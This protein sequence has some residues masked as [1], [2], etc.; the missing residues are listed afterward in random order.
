MPTYP[1]FRCR[2]CDGAVQME[3]N[4]NKDMFPS[5]GLSKKSLFSSELDSDDFSKYCRGQGKFYSEPPR[6]VF[7]SPVGAHHFNYS[8]TFHGLCCYCALGKGLCSESFRDVGCYHCKRRSL[9][10]REFSKLKVLKPN[11]KQAASW[12]ASG[13]GGLSNSLVDH[14]LRMLVGEKARLTFE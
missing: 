4:A 12:E 7:A 8:G 9:V 10:V 11:G 14:I 3:S 2:V 5:H 1:I 13:W 6:S